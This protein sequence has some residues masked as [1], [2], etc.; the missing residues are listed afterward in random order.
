MS[1]HPQA[2]SVN[3]PLPST[4]SPESGVEGDGH[5]G[6]TVVASVKGVVKILRLIWKKKRMIKS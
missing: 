2:V 3:G 1:T 5:R 4:V 6:R